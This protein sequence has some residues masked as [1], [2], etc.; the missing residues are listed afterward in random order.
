MQ[1]FICDSLKEEC[2]EDCKFFSIGK[3]KFIVCADCLI[4]SDPK[5]DFEDVKELIKAFQEIKKKVQND[6]Q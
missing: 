6:L 2:N 1:C 4:Y 3:T 5:R